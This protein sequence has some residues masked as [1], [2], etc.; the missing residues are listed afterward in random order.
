MGLRAATVFWVAAS[1]LHQAVLASLLA[2]TALVSA[3]PKAT[4]DLSIFRKSLKK[5]K[6]SIKSKILNRWDHTHEGESVCMFCLRNHLWERKWRTG[7]EGEGN[8]VFKTAL[9]FWL[10]Y[11][12]MLMIELRDYAIHDIKRVQGWCI[13]GKKLPSGM[14]NQVS[15]LWTQIIFSCCKTPMTS[16]DISAGW[17]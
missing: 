9:G 13:G 8:W 17:L 7:K 10:I 15:P 4:K 2:K 16:H 5:Q 6:D 11:G 3:G 14:G 1:Q 12:E